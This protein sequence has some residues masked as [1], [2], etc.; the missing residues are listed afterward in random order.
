MRAAILVL[1]IIGAVV[2]FA[3]GTCTGALFQGLGEA[4]KGTG[5]SEAATTAEE[6]SGMF[7][8][9]A[10]L[11]AA[12]G[13][14]GGVLAFH[15]FGTR[16]ANVGGVVLIAAAVLSTHNT[17]QFFTSGVLFAIAGMLA[18]FAGRAPKEADLPV[19]EEL[20]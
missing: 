19:L 15:R 12:V 7:M 8:A 16:A 14:I 20:E 5:D 11:E 9:L 10:L 6:T 17:L 2:A 13:L 1:A 3:L 18:V 4:A